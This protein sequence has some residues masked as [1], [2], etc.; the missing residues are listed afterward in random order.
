MSTAAHIVSL[1]CRPLQYTVLTA[2]MRD[3]FSPP[4]IFKM[5]VGDDALPEE[6]EGNIA[7]GEAEECVSITKGPA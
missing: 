1:P 5:M 3:D 2:V 6:E 7:V 4:I